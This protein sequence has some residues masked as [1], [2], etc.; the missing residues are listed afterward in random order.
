MK[1]CS[2][3]G[4]PVEHAIPGGDDRLRFIC[5]F[6]NTIHY[7]NPKIVVGCLAVYDKQL[8]LCKR[9][10]EPCYGLWTLP[11]GFMENGEN[12]EE[13]A[14]RETREEANAVIEIQGIHAVY[15]VPLVNQVH[16]F[17]NAELKNTDFFP[18]KESLEV[19]LFHE[20]EIPWDE[21]AFQSVHFALTAFYSDQKNGS[22]GPHLGTYTRNK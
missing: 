6:C 16:I 8:L 1:F 10:I 7:E 4:N 21:I 11:G 5:N 3:C 18:G 22:S 17:F 2:N 20:S 12:V 14:E 13:G 19:R 9:A 15:S